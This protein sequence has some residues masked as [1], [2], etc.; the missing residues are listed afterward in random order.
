MYSRPSLTNT[1]KSTKVRNT[2]RSTPTRIYMR[3]SAPVIDKSARVRIALADKNGGLLRGK[4]KA[5]YLCNGTVLG[6]TQYF[7][8]CSRST[9]VVGIALWT[10]C[11][12]I[13][14]NR[15][16]DRNTHTHPHSNPRCACAPRVKCGTLGALRVYIHT[17]G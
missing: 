4:P 3:E 5:L 6:K 16:A 12:L 9:E 1:M 14:W 15:Q 8:Q 2:R 11:S 7:K 10:P 17:R 13:S